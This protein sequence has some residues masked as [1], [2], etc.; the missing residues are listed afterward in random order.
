MNT[1]PGEETIATLQTK[2]D[3]E[4]AMNGWNCTRKYKN[5]KQTFRL[6]EEVVRET[7]AQSVSSLRVM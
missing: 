3:R 5:V 4:L 6:L 2:A 1:Q 7:K